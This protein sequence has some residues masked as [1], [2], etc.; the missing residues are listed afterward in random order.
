MDCRQNMK[1]LY[2]HSTALLPSSDGVS[3]VRTALDEAKQVL[4][5]S[6]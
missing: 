6:A 4:H 2:F 3:V 1:V 5:S